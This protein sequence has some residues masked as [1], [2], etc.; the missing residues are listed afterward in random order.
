M[1][2]RYAGQPVETKEELKFEDAGR[3]SDYAIG[4]L[5]WAVEQGIVN[6]K[7]DGI[8]DSKGNATHAEVAAMLMR[9]LNK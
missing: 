6:G 2:W 9:L 8:L 1:L 7:G 5:Q 4:A 3:I